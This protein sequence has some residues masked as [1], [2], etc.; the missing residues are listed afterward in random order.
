[1]CFK[2]C[3]LWNILGQ[4]GVG[5]AGQGGQ[6]WP[7][8]SGQGWAGQGAQAGQGGQSGQDGTGSGGQ[9]GQSGQGGAGWGGQ[10]VQGGNNGGGWAQRLPHQ[11]LWWMVVVMIRYKDTFLPIFF[12]CF[13]ND[14]SNEN[15]F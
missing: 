6:S 14:L 15:T 11:H 2:I 4:G 10:N 12:S 7:V 1:M 5:W 8:Q 9:N 13:L 3:I